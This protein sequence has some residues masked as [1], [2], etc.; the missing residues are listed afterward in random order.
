MGAIK[1]VLI[2][3]TPT[4]GTVYHNLQPPNLSDIE[5]V[6]VKAKQLFWDR[7]VSLGCMRPGGELRL[8]IDRLAVECGIESIVMPSKEL[9]EE[10]KDLGILVQYKEE[11]CVL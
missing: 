10:I 6:F 8:K 1:V 4:K 2:V 7:S 3:F 5:K 9:F 11:C